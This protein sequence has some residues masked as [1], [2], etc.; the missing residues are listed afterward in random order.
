MLTIIPGVSLGCLHGDTVSGEAQFAVGVLAG[1]RV[2][3][4][5][6]ALSLVPWT[7][8]VS[9]KSTARDCLSETARDVPWLPAQAV[10]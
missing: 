9:P 3:P 7:S 10:L 1:V 2:A 4:Q 6:T 5:S 8:S